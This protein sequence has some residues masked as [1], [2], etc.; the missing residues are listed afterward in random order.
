MEWNDKHTDYTHNEHFVKGFAGEYSWLSNF[1]PCT[2]LFEDVEYPSSECA[3]QAA[4][5][6]D[7][8]VR[9]QFTNI[10][11]GKAKK[12]GRSIEVRPEWNSV[13]LDVMRTILVNKFTRHT[14]LREQLLSTGEKH[15]EETNWWKDTYWGV[16]QKIGYNNPNSADIIFD[17]I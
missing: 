2:I 12:L 6:N 14:D 7:P 10:T 1:H 5:S 15:L 17:K 16:Y 13:K 11:S 4:K 8:S 9:S 3:Y